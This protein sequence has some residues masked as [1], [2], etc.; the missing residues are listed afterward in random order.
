MKAIVDDLE[1]I[2]ILKKLAMNKIKLWIWQDVSLPSGER[3]RIV[4]YSLIQKVDPIKNI[5]FLKPSSKNGFKFEE[6]ILIYLLANKRAVAFSIMPREM[7]TQ[8]VIAQ[9]PKKMTNVESEFID[10]I[11]LIEKEDEAKYSHLR[12][13]TRKQLK[14]GQLVGVR[15]VGMNG[16]IGIL[17]FYDLFDVSS[18]GM[19]FCVDD[20]SELNV[21]E[22]ILVE[23][24]DGSTLAKSLELVVKSVR[25]LE[26]SIF[27][28]GLEFLNK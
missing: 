12:Q 28:V 8:F 14:A 15:R 16:E 26:D 3:R 4:Q 20:P 5:F 2:G 6:N 17:N 24:I 23:S 1:I 25:Q 21:D 19:G 13:N 7:G 10:K 27:K 11:E 22:V 9:I 18:G